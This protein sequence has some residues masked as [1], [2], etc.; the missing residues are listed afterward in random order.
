MGERVSD[1]IDDESISGGIEAGGGVGHVD[2]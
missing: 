1:I 2:A